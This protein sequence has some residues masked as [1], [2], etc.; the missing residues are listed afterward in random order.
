MIRTGPSSGI[1]QING[2]EE[3]GPAIYYFSAIRKGDWKLVYSLRTRQSELYNLRD[4]LGELHDLAKQFPA[5]VKELEKALGQQLI[6]YDAPMP[7][8]KSTG[9]KLPYPGTN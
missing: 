2:G 5:K 3:D 9:L 8:E 6:S 7:V 1:T 4:D